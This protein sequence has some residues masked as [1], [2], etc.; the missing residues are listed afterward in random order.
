MHHDRE[1]QCLFPMLEKHDIIEPPAIMKEEHVEFRAKK[2][3][4]FQVVNQREE[5][6]F[7]VFKSRVKELGGFISRELD[8]HIFKEN[9]ILYQI[10]LQVLTEDEWKEVKRGCDKIGYCCFKPADQPAGG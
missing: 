5:L 7:E 8:S 10:A 6:G 2:K 3:E 9:N 4:V 1:E